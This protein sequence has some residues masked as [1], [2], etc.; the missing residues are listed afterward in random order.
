MNNPILDPKISY[1]FSEILLHNLS[2]PSY[3]LNINE[4]NWIIGFIH[5]SPNYFDKL[6]ID[7]TN[8][9]SETGMISLQDI[10]TIIKLIVNIYQITAL[11]NELANNENIITFIKY[12]LYVLL[13]PQMTFLPKSELDIIN[14]MIEMSIS[15][16]TTN[17]VTRGSLE[18][19]FYKK[20][21][22]FY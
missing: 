7:I 2:N 10:P 16:L 12:S 11:K 21:C 6:G 20:N 13:Q 3:S 4:K 1:N 22:C 15:L 14:N 17:L 9:I 19:N 8:T 18:K 5:S